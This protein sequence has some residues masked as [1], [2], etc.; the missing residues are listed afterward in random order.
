MEPDA[1]REGRQGQ[2][3]SAPESEWTRGCIRH[4]ESLCETVSKQNHAQP[5]PI[6][7]SFVHGPSRPDTHPPAPRK[8]FAGGAF[9]PSPPHKS[10]NHTPSPTHTGTEHRENAEAIA[11]RPGR[12]RAGI[13]RRITPPFAP[14]SPP[15]QPTRHPDRPPVRTRTPAARLGMHGDGG[16]GAVHLVAHEVLRAGPC[17]ASAVAACRGWP[18]GA[19]R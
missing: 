15:A 18:S 5:P 6:V 7:R 1:R 4:C 11:P 10:H 8:H 19:R 12:A 17:A 13:G 14:P 2:R 3:Q 16:D 9:L